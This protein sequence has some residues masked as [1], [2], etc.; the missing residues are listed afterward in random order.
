[1]LILL[2]AQSAPFIVGLRP[3]SLTRGVAR[4]AETMNGALC[5]EQVYGSAGN[6]K[7]PPH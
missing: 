5:A 2:D 4:I 3:S 7:R 1:M 6:K